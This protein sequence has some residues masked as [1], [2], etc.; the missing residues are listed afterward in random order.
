MKREFGLTS[1]K[2][3]KTRALAISHGSCQ[4]L[5]PINESSNSTPKTQKIDLSTLVAASEAISE[6]TDINLAIEKLLQLLAQSAGAQRGVLIIADPSTDCLFV[7]GEVC[8][9]SL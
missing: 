2:A 1:L 6:E 9:L 8:I 4:T 7:E 3:K 5:I